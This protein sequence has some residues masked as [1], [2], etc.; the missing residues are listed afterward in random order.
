MKPQKR[1]AFW[2]ILASLS[3]L[4]GEVA[5]GATLYPFFSPWGILVILPLYGLHALVLAS[6]VY[7]F[8]R[9]RFETLYLAGVIFG[10][11]ETYITKI[12]WNP[13]WESPIQVG[14]ISVLELLVVVFFWHPFMSFM[15]PLGVAE[16]MTSGR[17][18]LPKFVLKRPLL[19]AFI[20]GVLE[21]SN[22]P[23]PLHS[24]LSLTSTLTV[25]LLLVRWWRRHYE[26]EDLD[27][28]LPTVGELKALIP[29]LLMYYVVLGLGIK[30]EA[31]PGVGPQAFIWFLYALTG[32]LLYR[33]LKKSRGAEVDRIVAPSLRGLAVFSA[34]WTLS[35]VAFSTME[36]S[37]HE[38]K[39]VIIAALWLSGA[40]I[41]LVSFFRSTRWAL[42]K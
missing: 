8:G 40:V 41:G 14:G 2:F 38:L 18:L 27:N 39:Y 32:F 31:I 4:F 10:L 33:A 22:S 7:R 36:L 16:L 6:I 29:L 42:T 24:F 23:S 34:V 11:Y 26:G 5:L 28:L 9:P 19:F 12:V 15:M 20:L 21:S 35:G 1:Y 37:I 3:A 13:D 17:N 25:V 30:R